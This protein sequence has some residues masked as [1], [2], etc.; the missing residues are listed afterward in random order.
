MET[1]KVIVAYAASAFI[2]LQLAD[3]LIPALL[4]RY[5]KS[6]RNEQVTGN[7]LK[8]TTPKGVFVFYLQY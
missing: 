3:L 6:I 5:L 4:K 8:T 2:L 7:F 1:G